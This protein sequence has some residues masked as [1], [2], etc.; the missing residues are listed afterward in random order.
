[1][2]IYA[3]PKTE[4]GNDDRHDRKEVDIIDTARGAFDVD[5]AR[6]RVDFDRQVK[7]ATSKEES[8]DDNAH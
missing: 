4:R 3:S 7:L 8:K 1:M 5:R 6:Q 2:S